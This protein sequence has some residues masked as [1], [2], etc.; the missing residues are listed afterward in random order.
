MKANWTRVRVTGYLK[1]EEKIDL[2]V[3]EEIAEE[4][5]QRVQRRV[6]LL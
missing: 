3:F 2:A 4:V 5:Y 1:P 6:N